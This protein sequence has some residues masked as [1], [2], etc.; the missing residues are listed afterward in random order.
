[1]H[2]QYASSTALRLPSEAAADRA[3]SAMNSGRTDRPA[4]SSSPGCKFLRSPTARGE[5]GQAR[6]PHGALVTA[7]IPTATITAASL[8]H[9]ARRGK[10]GSS[11]PPTRPSILSAFRSQEVGLNHFYIKGTKN[12]LAHS[13]RLMPA[14]SCR[15]QRALEYT[16]P[17]PLTCGKGVHRNLEIPLTGIGYIGGWFSD[18]LN[19]PA[20]FSDMHTNITD[21]SPRRTQ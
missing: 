19:T 17:T 6:L 8:Q 16:R 11:I 7:C 13:P 5:L 4:A 3:N 15:P 12:K 10:S 21:S 20:S 14:F 18:T 2:G 1:M 9:L